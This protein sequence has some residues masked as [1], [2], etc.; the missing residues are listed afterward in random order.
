MSAAEMLP[1]QRGDYLYVHGEVD[2]EGF[3]WGQLVD[4]R[5]GKVPRVILEKLS[6]D[7]CEP[8][9]HVLYKYMYNNDKV[10]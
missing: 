8:H 1:L 2:E 10:L 7:A 3:C 4:G 5:R 9:T 6:D